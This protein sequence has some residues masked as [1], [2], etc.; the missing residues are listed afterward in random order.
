MSGPTPRVVTYPNMRIEALA[1]GKPVVVAFSHADQAPGTFSQ[2]KLAEGAF[3]RVFVNTTRDSWYLDGIPGLG[4]SIEDAATAL[5]TVVAALSPSEIVTIGVAA[6]GYAAIAFGCLIGA[7]RVLAFNAET[8][9]MLPGSLSA[10]RLGKRDLGR[11]ADLVP[12]VEAHPP[13]RIVAVAGE[14]D[15]LALYSASRLTDL[16]NVEAITVP[17]AGSDVDRAL[18]ARGHYAPMVAAMI[19]GTWRKDSLPDQG[20]LLED[21]EAIAFTAQAHEFL[22]ANRAAEAESFA[23]QAAARQP[24][25]DVAHHL[26][27]RSLAALG[28]HEAAEAAL[29]Q[30]VALNPTIAANHHHLGLV[31]ARLGQHEDALRSHQ[32]A[33]ELRPNYAWF[34]YHLG[35]ALAGLG[36]LADAEAAQREALKL[37]PNAAGVAAELGQLLLRQK[38]CDE[39]ASLFEKAITLRPDHAPYHLQLG[40]ALEIQGRIAESVAVYRRAC[41]AH[42]EDAAVAR[43]L[44]AAEARLAA[45]TG[46]SDRE[47]ESAAPVAEQQDEIVAPSPPAAAAAA[48]IDISPPSTPA[49]P[50]A[51][52]AAEPSAPAERAPA[53]PRHRAFAEVVALLRG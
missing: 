23:A 13:T 40:Q 31:Q 10:A 14:S 46:A 42:P 27:G 30:A 28:R 21:L 15:I 8:L 41:D 2:Y 6:G 4:G 33:L 3:N 1:P 38:A 52:A 34:H 25:W 11:W 5:R 43:R 47:P 45:A 18:D 24:N 9:L 48:M 7:H 17:G 19:A 35:L 37:N 49:L 22:V 53:S 44:A 51:P 20:G 39:A 16:P 50:A 29:R 32:K 26:L 36:R 12:L